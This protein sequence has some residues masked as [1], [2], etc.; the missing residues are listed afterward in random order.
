MEITE[1]D[2]PWV[3]EKSS[4]PAL[5]ISTLEA[6]AVLI[7]LMLQYTDEERAHR[8]SVR[9]VPT[10]T[11]NRGNGSALNKLM[12]TKFP[13]SAVIMEMASFMNRR[14]IRASVEWAPREGNREA[15]S[16]AN[17]DFSSF[18]ESQ[19]LHVVPS[20]LDWIVL[21]AALEHGRRAE[22]LFREAKSSGALPMRNRRA[23]K[24]RPEDR[25]RFKDPW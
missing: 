15:D 20:Q 25:L 1:E 5:I 13:A 22:E 11:D 10:I 24:R 21:P 14:G 12:S 7:A 2:W 8:S 18:S 17:G 19:R 4:K 16:L 9:I 3:F 6:L 23:R